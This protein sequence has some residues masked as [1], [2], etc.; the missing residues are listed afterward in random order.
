MSRITTGE[1]ALLSQGD[2]ANYQ[3]FYQKWLR[4]MM[5]R[6]AKVVALEDV[7]DFEI[8]AEVNHGRWVLQ[9]LFCAG[10]EF[11][12]KDGKFMCCSCWN[13]QA[14]GKFLRM[15]FPIEQKA[16]EELL[17]KRPKPE[18]RNWT[19]ESIADLEKENAERG[20]S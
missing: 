16:I 17:L 10:A 8:V 7:A 5:A 2:F 11:A 12:W 6:H 1:M 20:I 18:N 15:K 13:E 14:D 3:E 19:G 4:P 9:C